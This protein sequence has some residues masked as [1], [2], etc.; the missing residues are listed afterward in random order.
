MR[1][2]Q[3]RC[4]SSAFSTSGGRPQ[5]PAS[6]HADRLGHGVGLCGRLHTAKLRGAGN[7]E[8]VGSARVALR[9]LL[10][11]GTGGTLW[12]LLALGTCRAGFAL[13]SLRAGVA[14]ISLGALLAGVS[15]RSLGARFS[16]WPLGT[17]R[18]IRQDQL[19]LHIL[20]LICVPH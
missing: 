9:S 19:A 13:R 4:C 17:H 20:I 12:T 11:L 6:I 1:V 14:G 15:F 5:R 18:N 3:F 16:L 10:A 2:Y 7:G 8:G